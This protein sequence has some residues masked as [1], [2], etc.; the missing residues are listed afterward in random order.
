MIEVTSLSFSYGKLN[1]LN[2]ISFSVPKGQVTALMGPNG[3]GKTTLLRSV[4]NIHKRSG[5]LV[6]VNGRPLESIHR[7]EFP[8]VMAYV[9]QHISNRFP[10]KVFDAVLMGRRKNLSWHIP[11]ADIDAVEAVLDRLGLLELAMRDMT[12]LSGGQRQKV[13]LARAV[14][15]DADYIILDE[16]T[17]SLD[18]RHQIETMEIISSL[19]AEG[20]GVLMAIHDIQL[21]ANRSDRALVLSGGRVY[22]S[23]SPADILNEEMLRKVYGVEAEVTM[24]GGISVGIR[25]LSFNKEE[26]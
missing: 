14:A 17:S 12:Q 6:T 19:A 3:S 16:P 7:D 22:A 23:G 8:R 9:P 25:G 20:K 1:I 18:V 26:E 13:A 4:M 5:G 10:V 2:N 11:S 24:A 21:A 15:Q